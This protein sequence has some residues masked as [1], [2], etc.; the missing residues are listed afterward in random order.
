MEKGETVALVGE[1]GSGKSL[2][3][4]SILN[5]LENRPNLH[6]T[7]EI[8]FEDKP[9]QDAPSYLQH[10]RGGKIGMIFQDPKAALNPLHAIGHQVKEAILLHQ[11]INKADVKEKAIH[12]LEIVKLQHPEQKLKCYPHE[13]SGGERQRV[14]IAMALANQPSLLIADEP[15]TAL[16]V[17]TQQDILELLKTLQQQFSMGL[18][19]ISHDLNLVHKMADRIYIMRHGKIMENGKTQEIF[20][21]P[22]HSYTQALLA[23]QPHGDPA[24]VPLPLVSHLSVKNLSVN[25]LSKKSSFFSSKAFVPI[26][27]NLSFEV[28]KGETLGIVG[29]SGAGKTTLALAI[30]Q[31]IPYL[32]NIFIEEQNIKQ[33]KHK[34][35][36]E[37]QNVQLVFQDPYSSL[38]PRFSVKEIITEGLE[39]AH[40]PKSTIETLVLKTLE[41]VHLP[42]QILERYPHELSGGERQ[43]AA[44]ARSLILKPK[45]LI[46][47]EPTSALDLTIQQQVLELLKDLQQRYQL[48]YLFISH[49][50]AVV[51]SMAHRVI[52]LK[53]GQIVEEGLTQDIYKSPQ[54]SY[55][56]ALM[57]S[58]IQK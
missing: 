32:G 36:Q 27:K 41:D 9:V 44:I 56:R 31:L 37:R 24:S 28:Y 15:T 14:I 52:V 45:I 11:A 54:N 12:L 22:Q 23:S 18:L 49:D 2:T 50:L 51:K 19:L 55:T 34:N 6:K 13:L 58:I 48:S 7:G 29:E 53:H 17:L 42:S 40:Y 21:A 57:D 8:I 3:A 35:I 43:R 26:L 5:L 4:L 16:D 20:S 39:L 33:I 46:L 38:N 1:S 47:D 10:L 25:L 30:T